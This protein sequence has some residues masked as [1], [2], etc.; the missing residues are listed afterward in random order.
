MP[1]WIMF[2]LPAVAAMGA[3]TVRDLNTDGTRRV[4]FSVVW[5]AVATLL[6]LAIGFRFEVGGDWFNYFR[7][8]IRGQ[9]LSLGDLVGEEDPGYMAFNIL[10]SELGLGMTGV[11]LMA[12]AIFSVGLVSFLRSL[13]RP[14]LGLAAAV[15]YLV[16]VV[17]MGYTRQSIALGLVMVG[18]VELRRG[19]F[20]RFA[21]WVVL[22]AL[23]HKSAVLVIPIAVLTSSRVRI[24][25]I[26]M[27]GLLGYVGYDTFLADYTD[28]L[29]NVYVIQQKTE[30]QGALIRLGMNMIAGAV[31]FVFRRR[32]VMAPSEY[33]LWRIMSLIALAMFS[34]LLFTGFSTALDRMALYF[35]PLQ[36]VVF[37]H[38]PDAL[39]RPNGRNTAIVFG[40]L[41]Y[42]AAIQFVWLNFANNARLWL[43]YQM[44]L[45]LTAE[46]W[47]AY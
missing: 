44:G 40:I 8:L 41:I 15:P 7:Y 13:P 29:V 5:V 16:I 2:L 22:G 17:A 30:S 21:I 20:A 1:Y 4:R 27:V 19:R 28:N 47:E 11:N 35:I 46:F 31:F 39:G 32:F 37:S 34:A 6:T 23:F 42:F 10:S 25:S 33:R 38:L 14:W 24:Q 18:L 43:P 45:S 12:G 26:G 36:L 3:G 9:V